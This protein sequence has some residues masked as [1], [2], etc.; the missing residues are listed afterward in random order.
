L[1]GYDVFQAC[2]TRFCGR[3]PDSQAA[4]T[5]EGKYEVQGNRICFETTR[6]SSAQRTVR[7]GDRF[8]EDILEVTDWTFTYRILKTDRVYTSYRIPNEK[9]RCPTEP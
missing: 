9:V 1:W 8:C 3:F 6:F 5:G 7:A 2:T 4:F